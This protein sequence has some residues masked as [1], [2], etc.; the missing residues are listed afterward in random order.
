MEKNLGFCK[1]IV[2]EI[3]KTYKNVISHLMYR[4]FICNYLAKLSPK[5]LE[6]QPVNTSKEKNHAH[7]L[8]ILKNY[9][10]FL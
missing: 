10:R 5:Q 8:Y 2:F 4:P 1:R 6:Y 7:I 9:N 3:I